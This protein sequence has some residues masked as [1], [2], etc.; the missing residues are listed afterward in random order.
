M[1]SKAIFAGS[2]DP[3]HNGHKDRLE[4]ALKIFDEVY[5]IVADNYD[6][7]N[8]WF[9]QEERIKLIKKSTKKYKDKVIIKSGSKKMLYDIC[10]E[11]QIFNVFRGVKSGRTLE[12]EIRLQLVT[13]YMSN[14]TYSEKILFVY[15]I[16]SEDDFRGSSI[17]KELAI[18]KKDISS[19]VPKEIVADIE[20]RSKN[21]G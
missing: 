17:I 4:N 7:K 11:E 10:H 15:D 8:Y 1:M 21:Y 14:F 13:N 9:N 5:I 6:K 20:E 16:T 18:M 2:F 12:E 19:L 3:W